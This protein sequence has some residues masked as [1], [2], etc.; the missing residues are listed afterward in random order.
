PNSYPPIPAVHNVYAYDL[1][2]TVDKLDLLLSNVSDPS[3]TVE[4][5]YGE[6]SAAIV[7]G[8]REF[9]NVQSW[10]ALLTYLQQQQV[11]GGRWRG[12]FAASSIGAFRRHLRRLVQTRQTGLFVQSRARHEQLLSQA[13]TNIKG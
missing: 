2:G 4:G 5:I 10:D 8:D 1:P 12:L 6:V 7:G 9:Q 11:A 3:G 13:L